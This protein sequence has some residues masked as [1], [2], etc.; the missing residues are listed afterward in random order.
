M[1]IK[2]TEFLLESAPR[3]PKDEEYW[4]K[5]GKSGKNVCLIFHDDLDGVVSAIIMKNY[6]EHQGFEVVKYGVIN[7]QEGWEAFRIDS[8]LITIALDF[9]E[10]IPGVDV[11]IDHHGT[12]TEEARLTQKRGSIKT[13]T[14]SAAEGI[15]QQLGV[16]FSNDTKDWIDMIDSAKYSEYDIDIRGILDFDLKLIAKSP[17]SKLKFAAAMNQ[18]L[19]RSDHRTFIEVVNA[20]KEPSIYNIYRLFKL[21]YPKNNPNFKSGEEPDFVEDAK[22]RLNTMQNRTKGA[23]RVDQGFDENG[24]KIRFE[25]WEDFWNAFA[26]Q[27]PYVDVDENGEPLPDDPNNYKWQLKPGVYQLIGNIMYIPSGTWANALRAKAIFNQGVDEGIIPDDPKLNFVVLQY[28]NTIQIA[29]LRTRI[30]N[31]PVED[32][33]KDKAGNPIDNLGKYCEGLVKNFEEHLDYQDIRTVSGGHYGIGTVSNIF[34]KCHK[35]PFENVKFLDLFKNKIINDI[36]GVKWGLLMPWNED[37]DK[38]HIVKPEEVNKKLLDIDNVRSEEIAQTEKKERKILKEYVNGKASGYKFKDRTLR[39]IAEIYDETKFDDIL[40][41]K[42]I[43]S[44]LSGEVGP[45]QFKG[46]KPI[47]DSEIFHKI[48][49]KFPELDVYSD[50]VATEEV[51]LYRKEF[52]RIFRIM[53]DLMDIDP[54]TK[55]EYK[56]PFKKKA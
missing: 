3:I 6:L 21:F 47:E 27:L 34:G 53:F 24:K 54:N 13:P 50:G 55:R 20:S 2:F 10:D 51:K 32:L 22:V 35:K 5:K 19:K 41:G 40:N 9:A 11:Y 4:L 44:D 39:K 48:L 26:K 15:A 18:L 33:P 7:Y 16:P 31:M 28:G 1:K 17:K 56:K 23:G 30:Q 25:K 38:K 29:D 43:P 12:F 46:I 42:V 49:K 8:N 52:K 36:S 45:Q 37:E 14:G